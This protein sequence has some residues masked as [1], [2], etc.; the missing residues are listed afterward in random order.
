MIGHK[1]HQKTTITPEEYMTKDVLLDALNNVICESEQIMRDNALRRINKSKKLS[2]KNIPKIPNKNYKSSRNL[3]KSPE[4]KRLRYKIL[5]KY[6]ARCQC[7]GATRYDGVQMHVD[8]I[9]PYSKYPEL[10]LDE[11]NLQVLCELC[12]IGKGNS[13]CRDW[14]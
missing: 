6:G 14:R 3:Y 1:T 11:N 5:R 4:W 7:C 8:H 10:G 2:A 13:D 9:K 12:N